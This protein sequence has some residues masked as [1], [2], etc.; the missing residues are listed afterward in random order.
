MLVARG[1]RKLIRGRLQK[2]RPQD[3]SIFSVAYFRPAIIDL[4][5]RRKS[6][7]DCDREDGWLSE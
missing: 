5:G 7:F 2:P 1:W 4:Y 6:P 3:T